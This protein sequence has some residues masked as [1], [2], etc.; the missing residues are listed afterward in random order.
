MFVYVLMIGFLC[1]CVFYHVFFCVFVIESK[2]F[3]PQLFDIVSCMLSWSVVMGC[4]YVCVTYKRIVCCSVLCS[5]VAP[6][7]IFEFGGWVC[8]VNS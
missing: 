7:M 6:D 8:L 4:R 1:V 3:D 5:L 2:G